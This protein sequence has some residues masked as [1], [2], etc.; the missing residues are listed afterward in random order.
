MSE[1]TED[2]FLLMLTMQGYIKRVPLNSFST[3]RS[4]GIIAIQ[5]VCPI[6]W[7]LFLQRY[8]FFVFSYTRF[9][10][11]YLSMDI[12]IY[13]LTWK[14]PGDELKWVRCCT[15]DDFVAMASHNGMVIL[16]LCSKASCYLLL[17]LKQLKPFST[18]WGWLHGSNNAIKL[19]WIIS[20]PMI[21]VTVFYFSWTLTSKFH[22]LNMSTSNH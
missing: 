17:F 18:R 20:G 8:I 7:I 11:K 2:Q 21:F 3:I 15:N 4:T 13:H 9:L 22:K 16:S 6:I 12:H 10:V 1:F 19:S 5:L 14:V